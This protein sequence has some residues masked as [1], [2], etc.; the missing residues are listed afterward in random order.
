MV[1]I[2]EPLNIQ[3]LDHIIIAGNGYLSMAEMG[4]LPSVAERA[5]NYDS[6]SLPVMEQIGFPYETL[7]SPDEIEDE[8]E[9]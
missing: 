7:H 9:R 3:V 2:F 8:W 1:D 5:A 4:K 6:I